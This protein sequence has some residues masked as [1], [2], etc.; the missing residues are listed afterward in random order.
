MPLH[1]LLILGL[2]EGVDP[3]C[4][5][6]VQGRLPATKNLALGFY[7]LQEPTYWVFH[8]LVFDKMNI[9]RPFATLPQFL[10]FLLIVLCVALAE[11]FLVQKPGGWAILKLYDWVDKKGWRREAKREVAE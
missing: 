3:L 11:F 1:A 2:A 7:L 5:L 9:H 8:Y 6:L 10:F 4:W